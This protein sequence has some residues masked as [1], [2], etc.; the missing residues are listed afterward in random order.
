[1]RRRKN[2]KDQASVT[3]DGR[4]LRAANG[5]SSTLPDVTSIPPCFLVREPCVYV[6][7]AEINAHGSP[8]TASLRPVIRVRIEREPHITN[9]KATINNNDNNTGNWLLNYFSKP[10]GQKK[11]RRRK[12]KTS[13]H[14]L[15]LF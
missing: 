13:C 11:N 14:E 4:R 5:G 12:K 7:S 3:K 6:C 2:Y 9:A 10:I 1:M 8:T 15:C